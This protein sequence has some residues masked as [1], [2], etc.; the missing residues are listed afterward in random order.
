MSSKPINAKKRIQQRIKGTL[1]SPCLS[2]CNYDDLDKICRTCGMIKD[3]KR[4]WKKL[5]G[6]EKSFIRTEASERLI[7]VKI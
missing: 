1:D 4:R 7:K 6:T 2:I 5:G 3:E